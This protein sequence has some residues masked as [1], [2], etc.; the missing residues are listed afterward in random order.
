MKSKGSA[1]SPIPPKITKRNQLTNERS[2]IVKI[3]KETDI[4][5][6]VLFV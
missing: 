4:T 5:K 6:F 1:A 2:P 3:G